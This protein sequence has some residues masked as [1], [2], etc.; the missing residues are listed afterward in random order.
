[1]EKSIA[2]SIGTSTRFGE[3]KR[4]TLKMLLLAMWDGFLLK[5]PSCSQ[6]AIFEK[7]GK[8][9]RACPRCNAPFE[10]YG[11]G[12]FLG[13]MVVAYSL[14]AV[15]VTK[16]ILILNLVT[17]M[18]VWDQIIVAIAIGFLFVVLLYRNLKGVWVAILLALLRWMK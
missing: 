3:Q 14:A 13:A 1:M 10:R 6:G 2:K 11:E 18:P 16:V 9:H 5:C 8:M 7:R 4:P 17:T 12:D 15:F